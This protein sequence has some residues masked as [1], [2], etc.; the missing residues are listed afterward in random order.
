MG[1][2]MVVMMMFMCESG[3][4]FAFVASEG[5]GT[6]KAAFINYCDQYVE[7]TDKMSIKCIDRN[8]PFQEGVHESQF[9][10]ISEKYGIQLID[11]SEIDP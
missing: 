5:R 9:K 4:H 8:T 10:Q 7:W 6:A 2:R 11:W 1:V 3:D